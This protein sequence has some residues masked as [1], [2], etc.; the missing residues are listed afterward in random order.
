LQP[1]S[2]S[3]KDSQV[4]LAAFRGALQQLGWNE[5]QNVEINLVLTEGDTNRLGGLAKGL[6]ASDPT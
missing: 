2:K 1:Y 6:V 5:G 3:D 4:Q